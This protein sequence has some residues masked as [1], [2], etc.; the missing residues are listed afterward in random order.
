[1]A[2]HTGRVP[3]H[4][5]PGYGDT[6]AKAAS[7]GR[8]VAVFG[9]GVGGMTV[10][11]ELAERGFEVT[12][13]ERRAVPGGKARSLFVPGT[14]TGGRR[15]LPGEHGHRMVLGF[16]RNLPDTLSRIPAPAGGPCT[17]RSRP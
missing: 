8:R 2:E 1:M 3:R 11:H 17:T 5:V 12:V 9:A 14:G 16:Y 7:G 6:A 10:A 4:D 15:D 13:Y